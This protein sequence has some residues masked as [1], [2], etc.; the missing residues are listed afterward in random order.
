MY[1]YDW[2]ASAVNLLCPVSVIIIIIIIVIM[3]IVAKQKKLQDCRTS[4]IAKATVTNA[5]IRCWKLC[6][7]T[8]FGL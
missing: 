1:V 4:S 5:N 8:T 6:E 7:P 3:H 2:L